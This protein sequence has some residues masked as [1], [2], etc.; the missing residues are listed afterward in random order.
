MLSGIGCVM[1]A[2]HQAAERIGAAA[3]ELCRT[4]HAG[5]ERLVTP[6]PAKHQS[7]I[8]TEPG[9]VAAALMCERSVTLL[10]AAERS[11]L[12]LVVERSQLPFSGHGHER[13]FEG[14]V[15]GFAGPD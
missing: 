8:K 11:Q 13:R 7:S 5:K 9:T 12:L 4:G 3:V 6:E 14:G 2:R 1:V 15:F 10:Y